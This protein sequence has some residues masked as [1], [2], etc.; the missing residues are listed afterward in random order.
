MQNGQIQVHAS[1]LTSEPHFPHPQKM[2]S[3]SPSE[4]GLGL[5]TWS[6]KPWRNQG[7][8]W[9]AL[10]GNPL[11]SPNPQHSPFNRTSSLWHFL[12]S[13]SSRRYFRSSSWLL[14]LTSSMAWP[15]CRN[16]RNYQSRSLPLPRPVLLPPILGL[17]AH[18]A[19]LHRR[20]ALC[21]G[22]K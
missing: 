5:Q 18:C 21:R 9:L 14:L 2:D 6:W 17:G 11:P 16:K 22:Q 7:E 20:A 13:W 3:N 8:D 1:S 12:R 4:A 10:L 19:S 15:I